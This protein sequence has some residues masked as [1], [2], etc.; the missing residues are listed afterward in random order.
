[1]RPLGLDD[2]QRAAGMSRSKP[3]AVSI[4]RSQSISIGSHGAPSREPITLGASS[5][6]PCFCANTWASGTLSRSFQTAMSGTGRPMPA[7]RSSRG[8]SPARVGTD[9]ASLGYEAA[10]S[11]GLRRKWPKCRRHQRTSDVLFGR[12]SRIRLAQHKDLTDFISGKVFHWNKC[13]SLVQP[14]EGRRHGHPT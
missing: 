14:R 4:R 6:A 2:S 12:P 9:R 3:S 7:F 11:Q 5:P 13:I 8:P 10:R 1:M